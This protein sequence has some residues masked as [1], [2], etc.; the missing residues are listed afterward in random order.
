MHRNIV[1]Q[2]SHAELESI[3]LRDAQYIPIPDALVVFEWEVSQFEYPLEILEKNPNNQIE[4][5]SLSE[6]V[7]PISNSEPVR[8]TYEFLTEQNKPV[9][10]LSKRKNEKNYY[11]TKEIISFVRNGLSLAD[12]VFHQLVKAVVTLPSALPGI[13]RTSY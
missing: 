5:G 11:I 8:P 10:G 1:F 4:V 3:E 7:F 9:P 13:P 6:W 2:S 12:K